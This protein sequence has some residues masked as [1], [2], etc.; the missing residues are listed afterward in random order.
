MQ[1]A[2]NSLLVQISI[3][4][5]NNI[6]YKPFIIHLAVYVLGRVTIITTMIYMVAWMRLRYLMFIL[7][8]RKS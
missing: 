1:P 8:R 4:K 7:M 5:K 3:K 6:L 2:H